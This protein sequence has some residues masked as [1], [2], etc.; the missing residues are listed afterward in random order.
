ME[1]EGFDDDH[2]SDF[3][4]EQSLKE[5]TLA[6]QRLSNDFDDWMILRSYDKMSCSFAFKCVVFNYLHFKENALALQRLNKEFDD[7][8]ILTYLMTG[9]HVAL[10]SNML[11]LTILTYDPV[12][13]TWRQ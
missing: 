9:F 13:L 6:I 4:F 5:N 11:F 3:N 10:V 1:D 8:I 12:P 7:W 2:D